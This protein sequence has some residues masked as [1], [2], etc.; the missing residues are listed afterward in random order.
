MNTQSTIEFDQY[1]RDYFEELSHPLRNMIDPEGHYFIEL[2]SRIIENL[3]AQY[4]NSR[5][6]IRMVDVG[7]GLG[8][9]E[10]FLI[11]KFNSITA[12]DLSFEML[13]VAKTIN[14]LPGG[15]SAYVQGNAYHLPMEDNYADIVFM[16]CVLHHLENN[17]IEITLREIARVCS[18]GGYIVLFE[19]NP[20]NPFTQLVVRTTPL[21]RN[22]KLVTYKKL[23]RSL[24]QVG[25]PVRRQDFFL[26]G[27][28]GI[29][30]FIG[31]YLPWLDNLPVG[32][33]YALIGQKQA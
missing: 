19:H 11:P 8:L 13:K 30:N 32:G 20:Y 9:F 14:P 29:D 24:T 25:I 28:R 4:F 22:A 10:K 16:S 27:T 12:L 23:R 3:A 18:P 6:D 33:Q 2:K 31:H 7:T 5:A 21:D 1:A 17:E 26:Y 15:K